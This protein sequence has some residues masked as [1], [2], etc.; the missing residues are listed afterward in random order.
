MSVGFIPLAEEVAACDGSL[1]AG[2]LITLTDSPNDLP[3][4]ETNVVGYSADTRVG[5]VFSLV[6]GVSGDTG[7]S[8]IPY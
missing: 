8:S 2:L 1:M 3:Q 4:C 6:S 5:P 7:V